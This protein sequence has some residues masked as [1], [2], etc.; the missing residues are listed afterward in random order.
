MFKIESL[1]WAMHLHM[2]VTTDVCMHHWISGWIAKILLNSYFGAIH[3]PTA[4]WWV[5]RRF[6]SLKQRKHRGLS[7]WIYSYGLQQL[8]SA[9][10]KGKR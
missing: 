10:A 3:F 1:P 2:S 6:K 5:V 4:M 8:F 7:G 9:D